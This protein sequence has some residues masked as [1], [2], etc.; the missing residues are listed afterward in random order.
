MDGSEEYQKLPLENF[1][2]LF[3]GLHFCMQFEEKSWQ[4]K[5]KAERQIQLKEGTQESYELI[6]NQQLSLH[7]LRHNKT[8]T[9]FLEKAGCPEAQFECNEMMLAEANSDKFDEAFE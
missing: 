7:S 6:L 9:Q 2:P 5:E 1:M 3:K 4:I 8:R